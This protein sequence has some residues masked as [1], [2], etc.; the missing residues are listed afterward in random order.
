VFQIQAGSRRSACAFEIRPAGE[1][2]LEL[3][4]EFEMELTGLRRLFGP[5]LRRMQLRQARRLESALQ[6]WLVSR[7][8]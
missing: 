8:Q 5:V 2:T 4:L 1:G 3:T 7:L 6:S